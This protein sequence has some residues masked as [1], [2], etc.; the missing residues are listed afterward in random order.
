VARRLGLYLARLPGFDKRGFDRREL[1]ECVR[2]ADDAG[3]DSFWMAEAWERESFA[4]LAELAVRTRRIGLGTGIINVF[5]R[6]PAL[7]AMGAA[8]I[9]EMS[10]G[11]FR[12][13]LGTSGA[14]VVEDFH[15]FRYSKPLTRLKETVQVVRALMSG[16]RVDFKGEC[17]ELSRFKLGFK[18]LR[19]RVPIYIAAL[20]QK[21]LRQLGEI[22][23]GW[24][25]TLWPRRRLDE[26]IAEIAAAARS[27]GR[28]ASEIDIAPFTQVVVFED[29]ARARNLARLPLAY[30]AG[31]MGDYYRAS[32]ARLGF[33]EEA[34]LIQR[35]WQSG[36][37]KEAIRAVTDS[38]I[39]EIAIC[40][41]VRRCNEEIDKMYSM[42]AT[43]PIVPIPGEGS[44][45]EK[46]RLIESFVISD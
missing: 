19:E 25:P 26:G 40:G 8:T 34:G 27:A 32:L 10:G 5:S 15:G 43:L 36:R 3:Y 9:D 12:L 29:L 16:E 39:D 18:P 31:G 1:I 11:R 14:R 21:S 2:A 7:I 22:A 42:G 28:D 30:Y 33:D 17:F 46:C 4:V 44:T 45:V 20:S 35:L 41:P 6:S 13:G 23:D 38:M 24:L 37:P